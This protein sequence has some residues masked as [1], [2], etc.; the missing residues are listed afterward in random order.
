MYYDKYVLE[1]ES[2]DNGDIY[3]EMYD[4]VID[5]N[6]GDNILEY[7]KFISSFLYFAKDVEVETTLLEKDLR[8]VRNL[9][10]SN[11]PYFESS[12]ECTDK[13]DIYTK[14]KIPIGSSINMLGL[15][16]NAD[17]I[18][19]LII[20]KLTTPIAP[21]SF[22]TLLDVFASVFDK[23]VRDNLPRYTKL[24]PWYVKKGGFIE[25]LRYYQEEA[26]SGPTPIKVIVRR[27]KQILNII[28]NILAYIYTNNPELYARLRSLIPSTGIDILGC[29]IMVR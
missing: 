17:N 24:V 2:D 8:Y 20:L 26:A 29:L 27:S 12:T 25:Y 4:T 18:V 14:Q 19:Q 11:V 6:N 1:L 13:Y 28:R 22:L 16:L 23:I 10:A 3:K 15:C 7:G 9:R 21:G 5:T